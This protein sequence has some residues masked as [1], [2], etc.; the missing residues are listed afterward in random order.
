MDLGGK[1]K[2]SKELIYILV[3]IRSL[4][5]AITEFRNADALLKG[6][7]NTGTIGRGCST[8]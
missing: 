2:K 8:L 3:Q 5:S 7:F 4:I 6:M 1:F